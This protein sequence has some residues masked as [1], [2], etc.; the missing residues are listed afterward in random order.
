[1]GTASCYAFLLGWHSV[2]A[3]VVLLAD[4]ANHY[5]SMIQMWRELEPLYELRVPT[6]PVISHHSDVV[7]ESSPAGALAIRM[8]STEIEVKTFVRFVRSVQYG[9]LSASMTFQLRTTRS[10]K[11]FCYTC[12]IGYGSD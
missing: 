4:H 3:S 11:G 1:M 12:R 6:S 10:D 8:D 9:T 7:I 5:V 2:E